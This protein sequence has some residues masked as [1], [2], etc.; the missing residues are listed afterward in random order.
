MDNKNIGSDI[1]R[2][3]LG[4]VVA[5]GAAGA[6]LAQ[7]GLVQAADA[8]QSNSTVSTTLQWLDGKAPTADTGVTFGVPWPVG[9]VKAGQAF[10]IKTDA[11]KDIPTQSWTIASW[12]DGSVK[13]SAHALVATP[14]LSS[15]LTIAP[16]V[17][18]ASDAK[19]VINETDLD[20]TLDTG[21]AKYVIQ[22]A[23]SV[24][25]SNVER[26]GRSTLTNGRLVLL[27]QNAPDAH[28]KGN[29]TVDAFN[30]VVE[31]L[32][33]EQAGPLR[34]VIKLQG[35]HTNSSERKVLPFTIR[36]YFYAG[37]D[38]VRI[39]HSFI[40]D[41][42]EQKD[43]IKGLGLRFSVPMTDEMHNRHIRLSGEDAGL[44]AE[45]VRPITGQRRDPGEEPRKAQAAGLATPA[46]STW[47][48]TVSG[49][50]N[51][52]P[53]WGD[54]RLSQLNA[55]GFTIR[56]RT[57]AGHGWIDAAAGKRSSGTGYVG[58]VSG[59]VSF[60]MRDFWQRF[61][62]Q[63][64][65]TGANT[66]LAEVTIWMWSPESPA[67]DLRFYHD[68]MGMETHPQ[69][70]EGLNIT[71]EDYEKGFG[72]PVGI[73][74][75]TEFYIQINAATPARQDSANFASIVRTPPLLA[76]DPDHY[77]ACKVF[78]GLW[79]KPDRTNPSKAALEDRLDFLLD[80]YK[81]EI[82]V[83]HWYGFWNYGDVMHTYDGDRHTW[84]YDVG[85][86]AW[87]NAELSPELWLWYSYLRSGR[88][89]VFR[90]AEAMSRHVAEVDCYHAGRFKGLG[91]RHNVQ[92]WGCSCK[93]LRIS[94]VIY[95]R[96][97]YFLTADERMGDLMRDQIDADQTFLT[98]DPIRKI[99][100]DVYTPQ[101]D[102][103]S[104]GM[105]TDWSA[106]AAAWMTE[107]ER[108]GNEKCL[109]KLKTSMTSIG[110]LPIGFFTANTRYDLESGK[111][112]AIGDTEINI[113]H[114]SAVFGLVEI[115][116]E[117]IDT[118]KIP[119]FE[120]AWVQYCEFY[121]ASDKERTAAVGFATKTQGLTA[122]HARL[123]A[124]ASVRKN[125]PALAQRAWR[126]LLQREDDASIRK[127][128]VTRHIAGPDVLNPI[129]EQDVSTNYT[130]QWSLS[131][132]QCLA[133]IG[134][135]VPD[136]TKK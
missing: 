39:M 85:G 89:D 69:E 128:M 71:Y 132:I 61:P 14:N 16:G 18:A 125:D 133:L 43:F 19:I 36:L 7:A 56:K 87:D 92:H 8:V 90:M 49:R 94:T 27:N 88:G 76:C 64:D 38:T 115:C 131:A 129:D 117:L 70:I 26:K 102:A 84:R 33:I 31:S 13:W 110:N 111:F 82:D 52:I 29:V 101:P 68:G 80:Y 34:A 122:E 103:L 75:T 91:S 78:A 74:R 53:A 21:V 12:P 109:A 127:S 5:V 58:G 15:K 126:E 63:I 66:D 47:A 40:Y 113:S 108:T 72:T 97:Y 48:P 51:L 35:T 1:S 99:R 41:L 20:L 106:L 124:Y 114:L 59:G 32:S 62:S 136:I 10:A 44:F 24:L 79:S 105:G 2:R 120:K 118:F 30:G 22:R 81:K 119:E 60:G 123:T 86:Y 4:K 107:Y 50:L 104:V 25:I 116:G 77:Q 17:S 112:Y 37:S 135:S 121:S 83:H 45:A 23:G 134:N 73:A 3:D 98:L 93:Q 54:F 65:I 100:K 11:G 67:M 95:R 130:S 55:D 6:Y 28:D 96:F 9:Q 42:D 46:T 57:K